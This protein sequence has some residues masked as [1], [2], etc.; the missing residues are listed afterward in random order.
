MKEK[1]TD[2]TNKKKG[3]QGKRRGE[4]K[5]RGRRRSSPLTFISG[6]KQG[7]KGRH[8]LFSRK[9]RKSLERHSLSFYLVKKI[10]HEKRNP[11]LRFVYVL[12]TK[13]CSLSLTSL[14]YILRKQ[15]IQF[16]SISQQTRE[17][18]EGRRERER[19]R[20]VKET[21]CIIF[22]TSFRG[23]EGEVLQQKKRQARLC[24]F[25]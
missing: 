24:N 23:K 12:L 6:K 5:T 18:P 14:V 22:N 20:R 7:L 1:G 21:N 9:F 13:L 11:S 15:I 3:F 8:S 4:T 10:L 19:K 25:I 2:A 16:H 17:R